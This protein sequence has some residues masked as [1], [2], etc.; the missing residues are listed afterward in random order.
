MTLTITIPAEAEA[1]LQRR[2]ARRGQPLEAYVAQV[3]SR[4]AGVTPRDVPPVRLP[5]P[6]QPLR[7]ISGE[8]IVQAIREARDGR[9]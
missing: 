6:I 2:A 7:P 5:E 8:E 1:E 9:G 3:L 4:E